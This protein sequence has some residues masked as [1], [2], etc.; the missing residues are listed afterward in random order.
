MLV[1]SAVAHDADRA[2]RQ[3]HGEGLRDPIVPAC[4]AQFLDK[5]GV[6]TAQQLSTLA[7][8]LAQNAHAQPRAGERMAEHELA[9]QAERD[10]ELAHFVLEEL[11]Q[12]LEQ[13]EMQ[14]FRQPAHVVVRLD[15]MRFLRLGSGRFDHVG[16]DRSLREPSG[17][18]DFLRLGLEDGIVEDRGCSLARRAGSWALGLSA[19]RLWRR[20]SNSG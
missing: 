14:R 13:L 3:E 1:C 7:R 8:H 5:D 12:R 2:D 11:S 17:A 6:G 19:A 10:A 9:R 20:S 4:A 15:R 16:I 18:G